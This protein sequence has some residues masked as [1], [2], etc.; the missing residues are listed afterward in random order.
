MGTV[1]VREEHP[2][3]SIPGMVLATTKPLTKY[4]RDTDPS[5]W[6]KDYRMACLTGELMMSSSSSNISPFTSATARTPGSS[7]CRQAASTTGVTSRA[8]SSATS[9]APMCD[10]ET[11]GTLGT[12]GRRHEKLSVSTSAAS[13]SSATTSPTW[14]MLTLSVSSSRE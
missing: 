8:S 14:R 13:P 9:R 11:P 12:A 10:W 4:S 7:T 1:G 3:S 6:L 2:P 5:I